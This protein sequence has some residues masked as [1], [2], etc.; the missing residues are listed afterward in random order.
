MEARYLI[1]VEALKLALSQRIIGPDFMKKVVEFETYILN[2][3]AGEAAQVV[4]VTGAKEPPG[5]RTKRASTVPDTSGEASE[6][7]EQGD[8][9]PSH[10]G[11]PSQRGGFSVAS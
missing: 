5:K 10:E 9:S 6:T 3:Y 4:P 11:R 8:E 1:R 2:G 7:H